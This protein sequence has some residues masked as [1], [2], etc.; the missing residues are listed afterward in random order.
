MPIQVFKWYTKAIL[1]ANPNITF[2]FGDN[3]LR[4]GRGGQAMP[5]RGEP[6][7]LGIA[8]KMSPHDYMT[9]TSE[10][11]KIIETDMRKLF[12]LLREGRIV[13]YPLNG[14]GTGFADLRVKAPKIFMWLTSTEELLM[15][16]YKTEGDGWR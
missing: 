1:H 6:N 9:D 3:A 2:V 11:F 14:I 4:V 5:C 12:A 15:K 16:L 7:V 10:C 13:G 8:T